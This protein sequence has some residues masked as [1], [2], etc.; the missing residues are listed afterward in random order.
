MGNQQ[1]YNNLENSQESLNRISKHIRNINE[2]L[3]TREPE[4]KRLFLKR[5]SQSDNV[6]FIYN[7]YNHDFEKTLK[8]T[9]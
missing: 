9:H 2:S 3:D 7:S 8:T 6:Q 1:L 4:K 5:L